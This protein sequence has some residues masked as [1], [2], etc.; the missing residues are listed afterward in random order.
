MSLPTRRGFLA[1][2][3]ATAFGAS[4]ARAFPRMGGTAISI[5]ATKISQF[6]HALPGVSRF[7][8]LEFLG[9]L[10]LTSGH[11]DFGGLSALRISEDGTRLVTLTDRGNWLAATLRSEG[12][13]PA[14]IT[15]ASIAPML[16]SNGHPLRNRGM[17]D[18]ESLALDGTLAHAGIERKNLILH[19]DLAR[20]MSARGT[21]I[22]LPDAVRTLPHNK[23]L[24]GLV[25]IPRGL[26][27]GGALL[28]FAERAL[29]GQGRHTAFILGGRAPGAFT[30]ERHADY[31]I[32]DASLTPDGDLL[33]LERRFT[34][35]TGPGMRIRRLKLADIS[36]GAHLDGEALIEA[37]MTHQID[38]MEGLATH[39]HADGRAILTIVSDDNF[40]PLQRTLLLRFAL[41]G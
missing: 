19:Y 26:P 8:R 15:D 9:G 39:R 1:G 33:L 27:H 17:Q 31:D 40:N 5:D 37:N 13:R 32:T 34:F 3:A 10:V 12:D 36:P 29:D 4:S 41:V 2:L 18:T 16:F 21:P 35:L 6:S 14:A 22:K 28:A 38:N 24:E 23:G 11:K 7:G 30:L 20:G 25:S